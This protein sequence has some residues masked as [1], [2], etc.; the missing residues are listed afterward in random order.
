VRRGLERLSQQAMRMRRREGGKDGR[1]GGRDVPSLR[2]GRLTQWAC[3]PVRMER[4]EERKGEGRVKEEEE[5]E[6]E[7]EERE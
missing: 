7:E 4:G 2:R 1:D 5:E 3:F 6:E